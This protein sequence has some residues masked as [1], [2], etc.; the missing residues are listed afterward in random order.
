M[1]PLRSRLAGSAIGAALTAIMWL[2]HARSSSRF[3]LDRTEGAQFGVISLLTS[4]AV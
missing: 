3:S 2:M 4:L 1:T